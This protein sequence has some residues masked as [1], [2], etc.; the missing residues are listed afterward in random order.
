MKSNRKFLRQC[1][2]CK[3]YKDKT[4]LIRITKDYK[5]NEIKI[6]TDNSVMG[7]SLYICKNEEC[8]TN[9]LKKKK[10]EHVLKGKTP[11]NIKEK[12]DTV[13]TN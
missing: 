7:R 4:E 11:V 8:I 1:A 13:L 12:L 10:I 6:N 3:Q 2:C 5:T 9:L